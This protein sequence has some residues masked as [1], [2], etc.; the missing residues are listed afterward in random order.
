MSYDLYFKSRKPESKPDAKAFAAYF[1]Q[2]KNYEVTDKQ[3]I[4]ENEITGVYFIFDLG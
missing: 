3:A 2:R 4:Y 1:K